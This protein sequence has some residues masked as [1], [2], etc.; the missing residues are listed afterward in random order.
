MAWLQ[1]HWIKLGAAALLLLLLWW[2]WRRWKVKRAGAAQPTAPQSNRA[3]GT[4]LTPLASHVF[5]NIPSWVMPPSSPVSP[6]ANSQPSPATGNQLSRAQLG[7]L[8]T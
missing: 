3:T 4:Y 2:C 6:I 1:K 7:M 5:N 8:I